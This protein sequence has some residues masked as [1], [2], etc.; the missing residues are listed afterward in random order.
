MKKFTADFETCTWLDN[1]TYVWAW[2]SCEIG[3]EENLQINNSIESFIDYCISLDNPIFYFHNLK[4]DG[5]FL[6][7]WALKN[8]FKH[9]QK[10]EEIED[11]TFTTLISDM[12]QFYN[13]VFYFK[14]GNK[15]VKKATFIDSLKI[16][17]FSVSDTAKYFKLPISKLELDYNEKRELG[18][19]LTE[20]EREYITNDVVI[21]AKA[22]KVIFDEGLTKQ[23]RASNALD[24][25]KKILGTK[26]KFEHYFPKLEFELD[27]E[28]RKSYKGGFT[29]LNP[30]YAE[31][32]IENVNVLDVNSLYPS[33]MY[34][35]KLP[36]GNPIFFE[37]KY[38]N[39]KVYDLYIQTFSCSFELKKGKI[40]TIQ[41]K[42]RKG[43]FAE[44]EY[45]TSSNNEIVSMTLTN[46]DLDLFFEQYDVYDLEFEKGWK[47]RSIDT[48][49]QKYIDKWIAK[50]IE[51]GKNLYD[52]VLSKF[53]STFEKISAWVS[54]ALLA[55]LGGKMVLDAIQCFIATKKGEETCCECCNPRLTL[56]ALLLQA[57]ATSIDALAVGV[58]LNLEAH[59]GGGLLLGI[60]GSVTVIGCTTFLLSVIAVYIGKAVGNKLADKAQLLGGIVLICLGLKILI[61][62]FL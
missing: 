39:D 47:F 35:K 60:F 2:A 57:V 30:I 53:L 11:M 10:K 41:L 62:S 5:E 37:G 38:E 59:F 16:I 36:I 49:F 46:V 56:T 14:K 18:H 45:L 40:P 48:I 24:D 50:K 51:A 4:F 6:I 25:F 54:F 34:S 26:S 29:Y 7:W 33:V 22:L 27:K 9:V 21:M 28:L 43:F 12:G 52:G 44:N 31:K 17:P 13:I 3:N 58:S 61:E 42:G 1:E 23:T 32:N 20:H 8:G 55:F 15:K 19:I